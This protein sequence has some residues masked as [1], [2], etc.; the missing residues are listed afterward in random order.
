MLRERV[1][2][3][4]IAA[5]SS[6]VLE[7]LQEAREAGDA[8]ESRAASALREDPSARSECASSRALLRALAPCP[9]AAADASASTALF[10]TQERQHAA[11]QQRQGRGERDGVG[12]EEVLEAQVREMEAA[13]A[14]AVGD[15]A[16]LALRFSA[17]AAVLQVLT[18]L[19][20]LV[21]EYK[22]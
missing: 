6:R 8:R 16:A 17:H 2:S 20:L 15:V 10:R 19:A 7:A 1:V 13:E 3:R 5:S 12:E 18:L 21:Q 22:Y 11:A 14:A 9:A 4:R